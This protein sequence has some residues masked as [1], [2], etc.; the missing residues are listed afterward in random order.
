MTTSA[1]TTAAPTAM[2]ADTPNGP[3]IRFR[4]AHRASN[5]PAD[6]L[7]LVDLGDGR[8]YA[9]RRDSFAWDIRGPGRPIRFA[10]LGI[11]F[12]VDN[13]VRGALVNA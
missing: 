2:Q 13:A 12:G 10:L 6:T 5:V 1:T 7:I 8:L 4:P 9:G 11:V 3:P